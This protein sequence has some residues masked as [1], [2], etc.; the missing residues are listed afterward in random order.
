M[1]T[2]LAE[3]LRKTAYKEFVGENLIAARKAMKL[4]QAAFARKLGIAPNKLAQWES[5]LHYPDPWV[6][7]AFCDETGFTMD[8]F[9]RR[10]RSGV[11]SERADDLKRAEVG[12]EAV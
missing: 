10:V 8:W 9:Y 3:R 6:L 4:K 5:G 12:D 1:K 2:S 11:S 7:R